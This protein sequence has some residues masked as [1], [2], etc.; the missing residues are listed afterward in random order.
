MVLLS[1][2]LQIVGFFCDKDP[3]PLNTTSLHNDTT[4]K[5]T[6]T[7]DHTTPHPTLLLSLIH[8]PTM[9]TLH[10]YTLIAITPHNPA[11]HNTTFHKNFLLQDKQ[12]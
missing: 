7:P 12:L 8:F 4:P 5:L 10:T 11:L 1:N 6:Q 9:Q 3:A 2:R